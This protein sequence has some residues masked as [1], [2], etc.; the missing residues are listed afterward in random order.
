MNIKKLQILI[1]CL[2]MSVLYS[3]DVNAQNYNVKDSILKVSSIQV[4]YSHYIPGGDM[5]VR[6]GNNSMVGVGFLKKTK[7]NYFWG[8]EI[9]YLYGGDVKEKNV[10]DSL[11]TI[12]GQIIS[13]EGG[14]GDV[15]MFERGFSTHVKAGKLFPVFGS[16]KNS[17]II[18]LL[19]VG[20]LEH[21]MH[22]EVIDANVKAL[23][24]DKRKG[25]D[26]LTNGLSLSQFVGYW[27]MS[28]N[29]RLNAYVGFDFHQAFT[30][31]RRDWDFH[32]QRK[33]DEK[34]VDQLSGI[35]VGIVLPLY[36]RMPKDYYFR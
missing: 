3:Q 22:I 13:K 16:N 27:Y 32:A 24:G 11:R 17:G 36:K 6:F 26:R 34:R 30:E 33:L 4:Q 35:K 18:V 10:L 19:G 9:N 25:Y 8:A 14:Y 23:E 21:K 28:N 12:R 15:R 7:N 29:R 5:K 1:I 31:N 20:F 2:I